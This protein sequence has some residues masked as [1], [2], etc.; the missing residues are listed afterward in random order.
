[1]PSAEQILQNTRNTTYNSQFT[2]NQNYYNKRRS[3]SA[4]QYL[5]QRVNHL[6]I[7]KYTFQ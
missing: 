3:H 4:D 7:T 1:M 2:T 6:S 5:Q